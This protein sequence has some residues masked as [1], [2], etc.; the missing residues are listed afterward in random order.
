M[1]KSIQGWNGRPRSYRLGRVRLVLIEDS[2]TPCMVYVSVRKEGKGF[3]QATATYWCAVDAGEADG[4]E[5]TER[6][7]TWLGNHEDVCN[8][9][10]TLMKGSE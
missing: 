9:W 4:Y 2:D 6:E 10:E 8:D 7:V 3:K 1:A 5:L